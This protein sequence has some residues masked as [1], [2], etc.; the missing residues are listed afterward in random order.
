M[1]SPKYCAGTVFWGKKYYL[2]VRILGPSMIFTSGIV[3]FS[4][5]LCNP[6]NRKNGP[7]VIYPNGYIV[8]RNSAGR[9]HRTNGPAIITEVGLKEYWIAGKQ[10]D[11]IE[12]FSKF[13]VV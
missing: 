8:Y 5:K 1:D 4:E 6:P 10:I 2:P 13:G 7:A 11:S 12:F 3:N 9:Y